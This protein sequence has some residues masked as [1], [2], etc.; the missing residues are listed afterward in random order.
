MD[1]NMM[2][3]MH[4]IRY[5]FAFRCEFVVVEGAKNSSVVEEE[6]KI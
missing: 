5:T 2:H 4:G 6:W 3:P 1:L